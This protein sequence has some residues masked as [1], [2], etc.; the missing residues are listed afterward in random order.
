MDKNSQSLILIVVLVGFILWLWYMSDPN[1]S[2]YCEESFDPNMRSFLPIGYPRYGLRGDKINWYDIKDIYL[3]YN[4][5][6]VLNSSDREI[7]NVKKVDMTKY[8][9]CQKVACPQE[10]P[11]YKG[12]VCWKCSESTPNSV[13]TGVN[14]FSSCDYF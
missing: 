3:P 10:G 1:S 5:N 9:N 2:R 14:K 12:D 7:S 11:Y 4:Q 8:P 13:A 6:K